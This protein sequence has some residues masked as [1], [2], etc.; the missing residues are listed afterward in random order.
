M[1]KPKPVEHAW[2]SRLAS[3]DGLP[4]VDLEVCRLC[5]LER[6]KDGDGWLYV[7][8]G[9]CNVSTTDPGCRKAEDSEESD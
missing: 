7:E 4:D 5:G 2:P 1:K 6:Q 9:T 8:D 3:I